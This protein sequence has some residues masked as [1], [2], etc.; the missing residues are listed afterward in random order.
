MQRTIAGLFLALLLQL[1]MLPAL[2]SQKLTLMLDW[3]VNPDHAPIFVAQQQ[4]FFKQQGLSVTI[5]P[6]AD[7]SDP[8]KLVAVGKVDIAIDYQ[9]HVLISKAQGLP[10]VQVG[11]LVATPLNALAVLQSSPYKTIKDLK[12]KTI[13]YSSGSTDY[14]MLKGLNHHIHYHSIVIKVFF[15]KMQQGKLNMLLLSI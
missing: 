2:A 12:G 10:L 13:G 3:F 11:T 6:P 9:P 7:P 1:V 4:G 14:V 15:I 8:P 5:I